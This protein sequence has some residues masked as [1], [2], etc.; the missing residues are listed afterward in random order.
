MSGSEADLHSEQEPRSQGDPCP[1]HCSFQKT[2]FQLSGFCVCSPQSQPW[3]FSS[4][5][6]GTFPSTRSIPGTAPA[7]AAGKGYFS[8]FW[9]FSPWFYTFLPCQG[10]LGAWRCCW[11]TGVH[12]A[13]AL[14]PA[15]FTP[16]LV[17]MKD[18]RV[19][20]LPLLPKGAFPP[21]QGTIPDFQYPIHPCPLAVGAIPWLLSLVPTP[22]GPAR[23]SELCLELNSP[24]WVGGCP[25]L[26]EQGW[27]CESSGTDQPGLTISNNRT[28]Q[29]FL[30]AQLC[31]Q[32]QATGTDAEQ[33]DPG[34]STL[35]FLL[36]LL[37]LEPVLHMGSF[38]ALAHG[39]E[40]S[41]LGSS[42]VPPGRTPG[43]WGS[44]QQ[45]REPPGPGQG[46]AW[47]QPWAQ[48]GS[49]LTDT[50][51]K[52]S[53]LRC[54]QGQH[55]AGDTGTGL[56]TAG[57]GL[58]TGLGTAGIGLGTLG[59]GW[60]QPGSLLTDTR[61]K[62]SR[63]RCQQGQHGA[64]D[65]GTGLGTGLGTAGTGLGTARARLGTLGQGWGHGWGHWDRAGDR[66]TGLGTLGQGWGQGW[67]Q[68]GQ[69]WGHGW[70][71]LGQGWGQGWGQ[72]GSLLTDTRTKR[73]RLRCQ[74]GQHGA[75]DTGTGLGTAGTGLGTAGT[76][77]G[78]GLGT[79]GAGL[80]A[81]RASPGTL[82]AV[83]NARHWD[84][85]A[86]IG[87][88]STGIN[89]HSRALWGRN[90]QH[91]TGIHWHSRALRGRN[92]QHSTGIHWHSLQGIEGK[93]RA[94]QHWDTLAQLLPPPECEE[95]PEPQVCLSL[96]EAPPDGISWEFN[97]T[98]PG[99]GSA[100]FCWRVRPG[101]G[102][103]S[104]KC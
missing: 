12:N 87:Q 78:T 20:E 5:S 22:P 3:R 35:P 9:G 102:C 88:H 55:G 95:C 90:G 82:T 52:R 68:P 77:L 47:Q 49:L 27:V 44:S 81:P 60:G 10:V 26:V 1:T 97:Q 70:G 33:R 67:G 41:L 94:A 14:L 75:G 29:Q 21:C 13:P 62:R 89:W 79:A 16:A 37:S 61:T 6:Q 39:T 103:H 71:Q 43:M 73:S 31:P 86:Q 96:P 25:V 42:A 104:R 66:G 32:Q 64:G 50:R 40:T 7:A 93:E 56:G 100:A 19:R 72:P 36:P 4:Q 99:D 8:R 54:Q 51:T 48:L 18:H 38:P 53:R 15:A 57:K 76:G 92:G 83:G 63:L 69:G 24:R 34:S 101:N 30:G 45:L 2:C 46:P 17:W 84:K 23:G 91:S 74:Q 11:V 65:T 98:L 28:K 59:Q 85:L 58:G 80:G